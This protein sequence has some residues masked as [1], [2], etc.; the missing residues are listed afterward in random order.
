ME[1]AQ[2]S[3]VGLP[4]LVPGENYDFRKILPGEVILPATPQPDPH[5]VLESPGDGTVKLIRVPLADKRS[6][7]PNSQRGVL[8]N[9]TWDMLGGQRAVKRKG[10]LRQAGDIIFLDGTRV[11]V[12]WVS[13]G[14]NLVKVSSAQGPCWLMEASD[15]ILKGLATWSGQNIIYEKLGMQ[16]DRQQLRQIRRPNKHGEKEAATS[17]LQR[18]LDRV[19]A[20]EKPT[21]RTTEI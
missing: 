12:E 7:S 21:D 19:V 5:F 14:D 3:F 20:R 17:D 10:P 13:L 4:C 9:T 15:A 2:E 1:D 11:T 16:L 6:S 18:D 8:I